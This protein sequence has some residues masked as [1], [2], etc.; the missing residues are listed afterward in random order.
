VR[1]ICP[2][3]KIPAGNA[4]TPDGD[5]IETFRGA[6]CE[7]CFNTGY[8]GRI[9][10]FELME[11]NEELRGIVMAGGDASKIGAAALRN[12]MRNLRDDGWLKVRKGMTTSGEVLR[13]T[14]EF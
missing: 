2:D 7:N 4:I 3:C 9:G 10:I 12:G 13:V 8:R 6:G 5:M 1:T 11:M 14:Q